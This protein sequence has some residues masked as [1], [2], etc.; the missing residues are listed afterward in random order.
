MKTNLVCDVGGFIGSYLVK[1]LKKEEFLGESLRYS[2][3]NSTETDEFT[4]GDLRDQLICQKVLD[5]SYVDIFQLADYMGSADYIFFC[6]NSADV[7]QNSE[8]NFKCK[9]MNG[10]RKKRKVSGLK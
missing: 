10:F 7:M 8:T 9:M 4:F 2:E 5:R 3:Y 1:K 6:E